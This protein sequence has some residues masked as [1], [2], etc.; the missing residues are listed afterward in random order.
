MKKL[1]MLAFA[2]VFSASA[3][4]QDVYKQISKIKDYKEAYNLLQANLGSMSAE[5]KAKCYNVLVDLAYDKVVK[6][7]GTITENQMAEQF[8]KE[9]TPYDT[10][11]LYDA[12]LQALE[13]GVT[14]D[15]FDMQPNEKGKVKPKFHKSNG[16]RLYGIRFHLINAGIYYQTTNEP[17]SYKYLATYVESADYP[18]FKEQDKSK[19]AN[20]T[21]IAY[22]AARSAYFAKDY[23]KAEKYADIAL[24]DTAVAKD[25][26]Q[27][28]LAVMQ[29]QLKTHADTLNYITKLKDIYAKDESNEMIFSTICSMYISTN[30]KAA[31]NELVQAKLAKDPNNFTALAMSG[32]AYMNEHKWDEAIAA[33]SKAEAV[34]PGNVAVIGSIGNSYMYKAQDAAEQA[35]QG[36]KR[37]TPEAEKQIIDVYKQ[38]ISYLEKAKELDTTMQFKSVWAYSL[39]TCCYR[40]LGPD[41]AKTKEAEALTK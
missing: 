1:T 5:E 29:A 17:L 38:A 3:F 40:A 27:V 25:A 41:D 33:L 4:A 8:G 23:A 16:D 19:D 14:C 20:L 31:L 35:T 9:V 37:L 34:Q 36:G 18:L 26:M 24:G 22:Y 11:G 13:N 32:Q 2:A 15:E 30:D 7:Q 6:E 21:Q 39:Y 28:K 12:V 10:V